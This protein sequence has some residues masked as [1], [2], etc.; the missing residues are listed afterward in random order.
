LIFKSNFE[1]IGSMNLAPEERQM[2]RLIYLCAFPL[3]RVSM[4]GISGAKSPA[5]TPYKRILSQL[6][7]K[8]IISMRHGDTVLFDRQTL[9]KAINS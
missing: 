6:R 4:A 7:G 9:K 5:G 2:L 3:E 1:I 8:G